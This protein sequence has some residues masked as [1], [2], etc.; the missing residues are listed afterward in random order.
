MSCNKPFWSITTGVKHGA[1]STHTFGGKE[2]ITVDGVPTY[3]I[4]GSPLAATESIGPL[5]MPVGRVNPTGV[6]DLTDEWGEPG[7]VGHS[8]TYWFD[9]NACYPGPMVKEPLQERIDGLQLILEQMSE[10]TAR[11]GDSQVAASVVTRDNASRVY[12]LEG[13]SD[14]LQAKVARLESLIKTKLDKPSVAQE[15]ID[16]ELYMDDYL[17]ASRRFKRD[18]H[19]RKQRINTK[20]QRISRITK[21]SKMENKRTSK[22]PILI[23]VL[24]ATAGAAAIAVSLGLFESLGL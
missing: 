4:D 20:L 9:G 21:E 8:G 22:G 24:I 2:Y 18:R 3:N 23:G 16:A 11:V 17:T 7:I 12:Q 19:A 14:E 6:V 10:V 15:L 1:W 13:E 5:E